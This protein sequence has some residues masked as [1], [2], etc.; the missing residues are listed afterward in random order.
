MLRL[1]AN[2]STMFGELPFLERFGA[3][4][5]AGFAAVEFQY[6]YDHALEDVSAALRECGLPLVLLNAPRGSLQSDRGLAA[7][8]GREVEFREGTDLALA[9]SKA[10][11]NRYIHVLSGVPDAGVER[12]ACVQTWRNNMNCAI[13][14]A[15]L[16]GVELLIEALNPVDM[17]GYFIRSLDEAVTLL[18]MLEK[19]GAGLLFDVYHCAKSG[20]PVVPQMNACAGWTRHIQIADSPARGEPGTG[21]VDWATVFPAIEA[22]G[23]RGYVGA[24]YSPRNGTLEGL[25]WARPYL[26]Q[27]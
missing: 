15:R 21:D 8:P 5:R 4:R 19:P 13:A 27:S 23:Y 12:E 24:E 2:L 14:R 18:G 1:S 9:W 20:E 6:P 25:A 3:A 10:L 22:S 11:G 17:P 26:E 7:I 16:A